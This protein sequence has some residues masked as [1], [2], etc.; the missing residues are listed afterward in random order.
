MKCSEC[1]KKM[2]RGSVERIGNVWWVTYH[3]H[4]GH[5]T[6]VPKVG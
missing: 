1:G 4:C 2:K 3:C 6:Q 5:T